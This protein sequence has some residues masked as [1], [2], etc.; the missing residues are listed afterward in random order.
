MFGEIFF[1]GRPS[2]ATLASVTRPVLLAAAALA[3]VPA[4]SAQLL[5]ARESA[6]AAGHHHLNVSDLDQHKRF[7]GE[8]LGGETARFGQTDVVKIPNM[9]L[10]LREREPTGASD[11]SSVNHLGFRVPD[12]RG[13]IRRVQAAGLE[14][15]T[16]Q[17]V[18]GAVSDI[19]Y[20]ADQNVHMAFVKSP[21]GLR[22]ELM[23]DRSL[24]GIVA[25]HIHVFTADDAA[26]RD[27]YVR[28]FGGQPG[29]R[30][31]FRKMDVPG[32]EVTF[33]AA[34]DGT[35]PTK[36]RVLDHIGFEVDN[37]EAFCEELESKGVK[38]DVPFREIPAM[39]LSVAFLTDPWGTYI[40]LTEGLDEF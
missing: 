19:H 33:A 4:A 14:I 2:A 27:W 21:D 35:A 22:V 24:E 17:V 29:M 37:L 11:G 26:T 7:W 36:G 10:F 3:S 6:F 39:G 9:L 13:V 16:T 40:E 31:R 18:A 1:R 28:H 20:N 23:E 12:L 34:P 32:I 8:L 15:V 25:H 38:F 30:G 5:A